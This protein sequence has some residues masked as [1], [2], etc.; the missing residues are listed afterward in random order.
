MSLTSWFSKLSSDGKEKIV[1]LAVDKLLL[2]LLSAIIL[3]W[4]SCVAKNIQNTSEEI[5]AVSKVRTEIILNER[6]RLINAMSEFETIIF[7]KQ[8]LSTG[9]NDE[10][11]AK[12]TQYVATMTR[13][14]RTVES[15][16]SSD[17]IPEVANFLRSISD[18]DDYVGTRQ[19]VNVEIK[20]KYDAVRTT[21]KNLLE[22]I[23]KTTIKIIKEEIST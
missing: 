1:I 15:L 12:I 9:A 3:T 10:S 19:S 11:K 21:Y 6:T 7:D 13:S 16:A 4:I 23:R 18:F 2:G 8:I 5:R 22:A 17:N 14:A 20:E